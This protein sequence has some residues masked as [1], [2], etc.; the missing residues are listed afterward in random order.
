MM[1]WVTVGGRMEMSYESRGGLA[2]LVGQMTNGFERQ[3]Q[4]AL[5]SVID[6]RHIFVVQL[7]SSSRHS[8]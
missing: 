6:L 5:A 8:G 4:R 1:S 7:A 2:G 3:V